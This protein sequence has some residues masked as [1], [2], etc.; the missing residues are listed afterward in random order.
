MHQLLTISP[1][2]PQELQ[3]LPHYPSEVLPLFLYLGDT[4]HASAVATCSTL[5]IRALINM[6]GQPT[7]P[8][9]PVAG[10]LCVEGPD[11]GELLPR[12]QELCHLIGE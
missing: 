9:S 12:L 5:S 7:C 4:R 1:P 2:S 8:A 6:T 10:E 3:C 11:G